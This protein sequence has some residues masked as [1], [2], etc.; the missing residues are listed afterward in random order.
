MNAEAGRVQCGREHG[1]RV[2]FGSF[3]VVPVGDEFGGRGQRLGQPAAVGQGYRDPPVAFS[4]LTGPGLL[5]RAE[6]LV[7]PYGV[8]KTKH[9]PFPRMRVVA[10]S[11]GKNSVGTVPVRP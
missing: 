8:S 11:G 4:D 6:F 10:A 5:L 9:L 3:C 1:P 2:W 7:D